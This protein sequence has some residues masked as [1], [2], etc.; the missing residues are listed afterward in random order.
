[1]KTVPI[2]K[3]LILD[4]DNSVLILRRSPTHPTL[5]G[6]P[7]LPGGL[8]EEGEEP[9]EAL[10]REVKEETGLKISPQEFILVYSG[11]DIYNDVS[12]V[13]LFYIV[14]LN[15]KTPQI[16]ISNEHDDSEW[17]DVSKLES[18]ED[19]FISFYNEGLKHA[20][21]NQLLQV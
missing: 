8:I 19:Q 20:R 13:R 12:H 15:Q 3:A 2:A 21:I 10:S 4:S 16:T 14:K 7:D 18:I 1:M 11:T 17:L 5:A 6:R 9:G